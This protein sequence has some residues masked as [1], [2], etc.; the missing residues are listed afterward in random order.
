MRKA[1]TIG[2]VI[3]ALD[4]AR[5][6]ARVIDDIP[7]WVDRIVVADNGSRDGTG[8]IAADHGADV[9][10]EPRDGYG[11]ACQAGIRHLM[12]HR[13][14]VIVFLDGDY[15]DSPGEMDRLVDPLIADEAD[16]VIG[17]RLLGHAEPGSLTIA[18]RFGNRLACAL[19]RLF[20][21]VRYSDL[22]PFRAIRANTLHELNMRD[23]AFGWT[24]EMQVRAAQ[25]GLVGCEQ[26]VSYKPRIGQSKI[27][28][29]IS[30]TFRAGTAILGTI[31]R[32][33]LS[34]A[35]PAASTLEPVHQPPAPLPDRG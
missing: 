21:G 29:T 33:A 27:S 3:P 9:V 22:G 5:S 2:V 20:W 7:G 13:I 14:D 24:V 35:P 6:I 1:T 16:L 18:Q 28:G 26:P 30:G 12:H 17:S 19:M 8:Q 34:P 4:E 31:F 32:S 15:S 23:R 10:V 25:A 11:A